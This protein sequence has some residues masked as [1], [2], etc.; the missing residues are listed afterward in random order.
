M[1]EEGAKKLSDE[2]LTEFQQRFPDAEW[3]EVDGIV[4]VRTNKTEAYTAWLK[5]RPGIIV[6]EPDFDKIPFKIKEVLDAIE[7]WDD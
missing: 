7:G 1:R 2:Q 6:Q 5:N 4:W 3:G